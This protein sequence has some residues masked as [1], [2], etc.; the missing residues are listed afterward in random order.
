MEEKKQKNRISNTA[1]YILIG[2]CVINIIF[3]RSNISDMY[4]KLDQIYD[5]VSYDSEIS[6]VGLYDRIDELEQKIEEQ[7]NLIDSYKIKFSEIDGKKLT[8]KISVSVVPKTYSKNAQVEITVGDYTAQMKLKDNKFVG[9]IE[10]PLTEIYYKMLISI[11]NNGTVSSQTI[12]LDNEDEIFGWKYKLEEII[13]DEGED[14]ESIA[15]N[16]TEKNFCKIS[17]RNLKAVIDKLEQC[18]NNPTY[19][20][21]KN[22]EMFYEKEMEYNKSKNIYSVDDEKD[23]LLENG[24]KI[25]TYI[26]YIG[27][28][29]LKYRYV[30]SSYIYEDEQLDENYDGDEEYVYCD[31]YDTSGNKLE[32]VEAEDYE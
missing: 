16:Y 15:Y 21:V 17:Y 27:K 26:E 32:Y 10:I 31:V 14:E 12:N 1:I 30:L 18:E 24:D 29:G 11:N 19:V 6:G 8:G 4:W 9:K 5:S 13:L 28:S 22:N 2:V 20:V 3:L 7:E 23:V 25:E